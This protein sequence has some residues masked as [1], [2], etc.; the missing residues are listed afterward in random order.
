M[1]L[2]HTHVRLNASQVHNAIRLRLGLDSAPEDRARRRTLLAAINAALDEVAPMRG[3]FRR[4]CWPS[5]PRPRG[6]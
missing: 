4:A 6:C 5:R 2:A 3:G 1:S